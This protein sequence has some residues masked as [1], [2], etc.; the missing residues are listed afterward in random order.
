[1][2]SPTP[3]DRKYFDEKKQEPTF[4]NEFDGNGRRSSID[5]INALVSE[6]GTPDIFH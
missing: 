2:A 6:G 1:M 5:Y 4:S 3:S